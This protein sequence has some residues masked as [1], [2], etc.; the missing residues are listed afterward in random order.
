[1]R[2]RLGPGG[3]AEVSQDGGHPSCLLP[4]AFPQTPQ[5]PVFVLQSV[6]HCPEASQAELQVLQLLLQRPP[7][8]Q[9]LQLLS[10][11]LAD[12]PSLDSLL[13]LLHLTE[14]LL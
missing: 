7:P 1:M 4:P 3:Q 14:L 12:L 10:A 9:L 5:S 13:Q 11:G 2:E 6:S 8:R